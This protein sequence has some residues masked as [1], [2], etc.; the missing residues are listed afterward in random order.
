MP[1]VIPLSDYTLKKIRATQ[2]F[3]LDAAPKSSP[4]DINLATLMQESGWNLSDRLRFW[5]TLAGMLPNSRLTI[6]KLDLDEKALVHCNVDI[7]GALWILSNN[8]KY[9][10]R[11]FR[12]VFLNSPPTF[13]GARNWKVTSGWI[14][15]RTT[16][17]I[18]A[19]SVAGALGWGPN[20]P[21]E[22]ETSLKEAL[23]NLQR[24]NWKS[25][26]VMC[27]RALQALMEVAYEKQFGTQ[28]GKLNLNAITRKF[29]ALRPQPIPQHL[30][31][32]AD[33]VRNIGNVPGAHP[34]AI[35]GY[36]FSKQDAELAYTNAS[37]FVAAYFEK[38]APPTI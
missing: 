11:F 31:N 4:I 27:R 25:C 13:A 5:H 2:V 18:F 6:R 1:R 7:D 14:A 8:R 12:A 26:V 21:N 35:P 24:G 22:I 20:V 17:A 34:R 38:I 30:L 19:G 28:P 9:A 15:D 23:D 32:I 16:V 36:R 33:S 37:G 3:R 29:E 10:T